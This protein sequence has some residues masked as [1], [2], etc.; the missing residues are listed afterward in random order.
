MPPNGHH[1]HSLLCSYI[2]ARDRVVAKATLLRSHLLVSLVL[3]ANSLVHTPTMVVLIFNNQL[4]DCIARPPI[5]ESHDTHQNQ[6][7]MG[8]HEEIP[9]LQQEIGVAAVQTNQ[10]TGAADTQGAPPFL[11]RKLLMC[12]DGMICCPFNGGIRKEVDHQTATDST[13][14]TSCNCDCKASEE[15]MAIFSDS[16]IST[17]SDDGDW[18]HWHSDYSDDDEEEDKAQRQLQLGIGV[19]A[20]RNGE[21]PPRARWLRRRYLHFMMK[22]RIAAM[23]CA[24]WRQDDHDGKVQVTTALARSEINRDSPRSGRK[25]KRKDSETAIVTSEADNRNGNIDDDS[26]SGD[27]STRK[28]PELGSCHGSAADIIQRVEGHVVIEVDAPLVPIPITGHLSEASA[29][30]E[31][32][33]RSQRIRKKLGSACGTS[34]NRRS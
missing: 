33:R 5:D 34:P 31:G 11:K 16:D 4:F 14:E 6:T 2:I 27:R 25:R 22:R 19:G 28:R 17:V 29:L 30:S 3:L 20:S 24:H 26:E 12:H 1:R 10:D 13:T 9:Y 8:L 23:K 15:K 18:I 32:R 7:W 21:L